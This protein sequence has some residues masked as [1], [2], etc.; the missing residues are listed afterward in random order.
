MNLTNL[1]KFEVYFVANSIATNNTNIT[2]TGDD[3]EKLD[4]ILNILIIILLAIVMMGMG[5]GVEIDK[6]KKH[7]RKPTGIIVGF[8][9]QFVFMPVLAYLFSLA[10]TLETS[11]TIAILIQA[12]C[13]GGSVSNVAAYWL[14]G[15][16]DLSISMTS[17]STILALGMMPLLLFIFSGAYGTELPVPFET[18]GITLASLLVPILIGILLRHFF[19]KKAKIILKVC[20]IGGVILILGVAVVSVV[21]FEGQWKLEIQTAFACILL[22]PCGMIIGYALSSL[23]SLYKPL[24]MTHKQRRTISMETGIQ[25]TNLCGSVILLANFPPQDLGGMFLVPI[26]YVASQ[27]FFAIVFCL[28]YILIKRKCINKKDDTPS[29][30]KDSNLS[31]KESKLNNKTEDLS[32]TSFSSYDKKEQT[33]SL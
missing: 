26:L 33:I 19:P 27:V 18:I 13:P 4:K 25:N 15:D 10:F 12:S 30:S 9:S 8:I 11:I 29:I 2:K 22:P 23:V 32:M 6:L 20:S 24:H 28:L 3:E 17:C 1:T 31:E 5:C 21:L 16:I 14:N 7:L